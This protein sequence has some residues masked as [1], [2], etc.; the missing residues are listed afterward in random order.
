MRSML[1]ALFLCVGTFSVFAQKTVLKYPFEFRKVYFLD[2]GTY[3]ANF[4][5]NGQSDRFALVLKDQ[6]HCSYVLVDGDFKVVNK[7]DQD[8]DL[9]FFSAG[10]D[11]Y[12]GGTSDGNVYNFAFSNGEKTYKLE[13]VDFDKNSI[14]HK[15]LFELMKSEK[16]VAAFSE[17]NVFY[18]IGAN[19]DAGQL[20]FH[21]MDGKGKVVVKRVALKVPADAGKK[22]DQ[23]SEYLKNSRLIQGSMEPD[24]SLVTTDSKIF[25]QAGKL[26]IVVNVK[27]HPTHVT[28]IDLVDFKVQEKFYD[29]KSVLAGDDKG[30]VYVNSY[31]KDNTLFSLVLNKKNIHIVQFN[32]ESGQLIDNLEI[33]SENYQ[34]LMSQL[35]ATETRKGKKE[36]EKEVSS[37]NSLLKTMNKGTEGLMVT[38]DKDGQY[39]LTVGTY[40]FLKVPV[41]SGSGHYGPYAGPGARDAGSPQTPFYYTPGKT[42]YSSN[43]AKYY[44]ATTFSLL[45]DPASGKVK[46]GKVPPPVSDKVKDYLE[47]VDQQNAKAQIQFN[48]GDKQ[49]FGYYNKEAKAYIIAQIKVSM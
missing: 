18:V 42:I 17:Q 14:T 46:R 5:N 12:E 25:S 37:F 31:V 16:Q 29:Y 48:I 47:T 22:R 27:D 35:P 26:Y 45:M 19:D 2:P 49:Y 4:L 13:Q 7:F 38:A 6:K 24:F 23:V 1:L 36:S 9:K 28:T 30:G 39:V 21:M 10:A 34:S 15:P 20:Q 41:G 40:D 32:L 11:R 3:D 43:N 8:L 44:T 33:N